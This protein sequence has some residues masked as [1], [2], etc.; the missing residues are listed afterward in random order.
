ML[1][2]LQ[3]WTTNRDKEDANTREKLQEA[4]QQ[5]EN[6]TNELAQLRIEYKAYKARAHIALSERGGVSSNRVVA[7][8]EHCIQRLEREKL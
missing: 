1:A 8:L 3:D 4:L 7:E 5:V 2:D 6:T